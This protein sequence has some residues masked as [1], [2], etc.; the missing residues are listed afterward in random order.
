[1]FGLGL[2]ELVVIAVVWGIP[3]TIGAVL[4]KGKGRSGLGWF[5]LSAFFWFPI[6]IVVLLPPAREVPASWRMPGMQRNRQVA[7]DG[8][9][10]LSRESFTRAELIEKN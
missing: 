3:G 7:R 2:P 5:F 9:Q 10:T 1:M 4:A 6:L 8:L